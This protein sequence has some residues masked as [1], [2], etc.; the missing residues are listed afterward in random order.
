MPIKLRGIRLNVKARES[1][2]YDRMRDRVL[3][4]GNEV[5]KEPIILE[6]R[7]LQPDKRGSV[8]TMCESIRYDEHYQKGVTRPD[9]TIVPFGYCE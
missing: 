4:T 9:Y 5:H 1:L 3:R 6:Y 8:Y 7:R 2:T